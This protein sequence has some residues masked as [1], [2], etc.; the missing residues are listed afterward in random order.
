MIGKMLERA[1]RIAGLLREHGG[2][3]VTYS[4]LIQPVWMTFRQELMKI[5]AGGM[6][7]GYKHRDA[8]GDGNDL[9]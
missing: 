2:L 6:N 9:G 1:D 8:A 5:T 3:T 7:S 4:G